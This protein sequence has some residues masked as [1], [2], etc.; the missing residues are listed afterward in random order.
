MTIQ[1]DATLAQLSLAAYSD[2]PTLPTGYQAAVLPGL[3]ANGVFHNA[4]AAALVTTATLEG[5]TSIVIAFRGSDDGT[6][7]LHD[8]QGINQDFP[9]F[10]ELIA[11]VDYAALTYGFDQVVVTGHSLGGAFAQLYMQAHPDHPGGLVYDAATFGSPGAVLPPGG[12]ARPTNY[13]I[14]DD[15]AVFLGAH[16]AEVGDA[17]RANR[18]LADLAGDEVAAQFPGISKSQA[19][20]TLETLTV[21]YSNRG[22]I[23]LLPGDDRDLSPAHDVAGLA[24]LDASQHTPEL[25][26]ATLAQAAAGQLPEIFIP[27]APQNNDGL[28]FLRNVYNSDQGDDASAE[29]IVTDLLEKF[30]RQA[31]DSISGVANDGFTTVRDG[32]AG[33]GSDLNLI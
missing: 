8:L 30:V 7:S 16:R 13:V 26:V 18:V 6:D 14:A 3:A 10:A 5:K 23:L 4:N 1:T 2:N 9:L 12:D 15:P 19:L 33:I 24:R 22:D 21:N 11:K 32:L 20:S 27:T 28:A 31:G 25:Y 29:A 17:L